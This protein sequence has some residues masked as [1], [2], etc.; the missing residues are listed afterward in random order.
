MESLGKLL[1]K[2]KQALGRDTLSKEIILR[3]VKDVLGFEIRTQDVSIKGG[4]L[5]I[6]TTPAKRNEISLNEFRILEV[7]RLKTGLN[8]KRIVY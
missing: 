2:L 5:R 4:M 3:C 6:Q 1:G 8:L 7:I